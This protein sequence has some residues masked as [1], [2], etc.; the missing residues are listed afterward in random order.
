M[1]GAAVI[2]RTKDAVYI[3]IPEGM[4]KEIEGGCD[5]E[6]C[7][8]HAGRKP[9]WDTLVVSK[10]RPERMRRMRTSDYAWTVH[11]PDPVTFN[12]AIRMKG[13]EE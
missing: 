4:A 7:K 10:A 11:M 3:R 13:V 6:W 9:L 1:N 12:A 5:C 8:Q 2:A